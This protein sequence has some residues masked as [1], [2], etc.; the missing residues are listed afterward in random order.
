MAKK[1]MT[2]EEHATH[3]HYNEFAR[4]WDI[5][6]IC[7]ATLESRK[8]LLIGLAV[9]RSEREGH[10]TSEQREVFA[11]LAPH[12]RAAVRMQVALEGNGAVLLK[13]GLDR[14]RERRAVLRQ[15]RRQLDAVLRSQRS[16]LCARHRQ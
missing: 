6:Y 13:G 11:S 1:S 10:I 12:V 9:V 16:E 2:P 7:L 4:P 14:H 15:P 5:P 8:E 3:P